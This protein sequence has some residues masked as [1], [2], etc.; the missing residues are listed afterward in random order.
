[1][2]R[3]LVVGTT[4]SGKTTTAAAIAKRIGTS[5]VELDSL[6]WKPNWVESERDE[7]RACVAAATSDDRW[8]ADGNYL[9]MLGD[10]LWSRADTV[11]WLDPPLPLIVV[12]LIRR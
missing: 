5:H 1:M 7:F 2:N 4:G 8:V 11:V 3:V 12:R 9:G 10:M 6:F